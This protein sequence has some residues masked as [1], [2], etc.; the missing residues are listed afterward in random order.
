M[1]T[2]HRRLDAIREDR[3]E[4]EN[5]YIDALVDGHISRRQF[6][7][8]GAVLGLS[9]GV[10]GAV[11]AACGSANKTGASASSTASSTTSAAAVK[12]G[13]L[14]FGSQVPAASINPLTIADVGGLN[15]ICQTGEFLARD[16]VGTLEP[17]LATKWAPSADGKT[18]TFTLRK[19]VK[20]HDGSTMTA[21]DVVYTFKQLADPKNSSNALS[22]FNG[23]LSEAGIR[24]VD[25]HTVA[26]HLEAANGNFPFV[27]SSDN[28][29]AIIVPKGTDYDKWQK[30]FV[31]TGP[32]ILKSY[33]QN[34]GATFAPNPDYWGAKPFLA[35]TSFTFYQS[36]QPAIVALQGGQVDGIV[37]FVAQGAQAILGSS[38]Y[39]I[40]N[41]KSSLH[42]ELSMRC[43]QKPFNDPRVREAMA[44]TLNRPDMVKALLDGYGQV[45][46]D[47]PFAPVFKSTDMSVPQRVQNIA[48]AKS[49]LA[50][51]GHP[52]GFSATLYTEQYEEIPELAQVIKQQASAAGI[53]INLKVETQDSYYG[54]ATY[55]NSNWL[56]GEMSLV[57]YGDRGVPNVFLQAT[58][59][60]VGPWNAAHFRSAEYDN[61]VAKYVATVDL[62]TQKTIAGKIET[63]LLAQTP[64]IIPYFFDGLTATTQS[65]QGVVPTGLSQ[66]F[67]GKASLTSA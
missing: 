19:G 59:T 44:L 10:M 12:G 21:D 5:H 29:N 62:S 48:K 14:K 27:V 40:I 35:G 8:K 55:G 22:T 6:V 64:L 53:D 31:G 38:K 2:D 46:N 65:V 51:A 61:L 23:V 43:D 34:Q 66:V 36:Q 9:A 13:T 7:Q 54:K 15:M 30:T 45:G 33:T 4:I 18:Y 32:F 60:K 58:L 26:F 41:Q 28:Y 63:L 67:L 42:R 39:K 11:L 47:S 1:S 25:D 49:L 20:F 24:K 16:N 37:E 17:S 52:K 57:D 50:A 56:D 3:S